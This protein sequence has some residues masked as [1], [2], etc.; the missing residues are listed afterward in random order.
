M[1]PPQRGGKDPSGPRARRGGPSV[2]VAPAGVP[3]WSEAQAERHLRSLELFG[4]RFGLEKMRRMMTVLGSPE[5]RFGSIHIVGTNGKTSTARLTAAILQRHGLRT[6][7][8]TSPHLASY[9]ERVQVGEREVSGEEFAAAIARAAWASE[10]VNRTLQGD[11]HVTQFELLTAAAFFQMARRE[12]QVGVIEAGVG[13]RY[14]ATSGVRARRGTFSARTSRWRAWPRRCIWRARA[15]S[16]ARARWP[17]RPPPRSCRAACR[18]WAMTRSRCSTARTT[19]T[20]CARSCARCRR[21]S[22]RG[23][24]GS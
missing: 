4:M 2:R 12:V 5:R 15:S 9:R 23:R 22:A 17:R 13:G 16:R 11:D 3:R 19:R 21:C 6:G 10:R 24:W 8:Y 14:G 18:W 20:R 7:T 1:P